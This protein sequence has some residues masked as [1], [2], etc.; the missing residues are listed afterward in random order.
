[1]SKTVVARWRADFF[2]GL[3]VLL[4]AILTVWLVWWIVRNIAAVTDTLLFF[5]PRTWTHAADGT[6]LW[7]WSV[8]ALVF[9]V[10]VLAAVGRLAR[11]Y[12]GRKVL[13]LLD[14]VLLRLPLV[15][16]IYGTIK[17]V[18]EAFTSGK[19]SSF[20][21]VVLVEFPQPGHRS[22]GF[23]T[24][25]P[26]PEL[27]GPQTEPML[28]VFV[29]TTPN[30]TSGFLIVVPERSV[31]RL[32]MPVSDGIKFIISLGSLAPEAALRDELRR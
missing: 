5:L 8:L 6:L 21:E 30:P 20:Q 10:L 4:P 22:I 9:A 1:M 11:F 28:N 17:Q 13:G 14:Q 24:G 19:K 27:T 12:L 3:A 29:P 2:A 23:I 7:W 26:S 15:N 32:D 25:T 18:N 31:R 16:K